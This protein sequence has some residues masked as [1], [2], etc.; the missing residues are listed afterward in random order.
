MK[1]NNMNV[2]LHT[3]LCACA[4]LYVYVPREVGEVEEK[5]RALPALF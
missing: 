4:N 1:N 2:T 3:G 5:Q